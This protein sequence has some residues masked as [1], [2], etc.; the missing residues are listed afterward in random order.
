MGSAWSVACRFSA[1]L[2]V[3]LGKLIRLLARVDKSIMGVNEV[4]RIGD[5]RTELFI[6]KK[7]KS[8]DYQYYHTFLILIIL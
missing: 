5:A 3:V 2:G 1:L 7:C 6:W 4:N 8:M